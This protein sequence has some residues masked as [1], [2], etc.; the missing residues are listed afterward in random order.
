MIREGNAGGGRGPD[1]TLSLIEIPVRS[2]W[3]AC[4]H[5]LFVSADPKPT[6]ST[7]PVVVLE[8]ILDY[9][10]NAAD[11]RDT[12]DDDSRHQW[13]N[14]DYTFFTAILRVSRD[15]RDIGSRI[16]E[17]N[18]F[19][20][21]S[22]KDPSFLRNLTGPAVSEGCLLRHRIY[23]RF[24]AIA[25]FKRYHMRVHISLRNDGLTTKLESVFFILPMDNLATF[26]SSL[27]IPVL[28]TASS[29]KLLIELK[30]HSSG[31]SLITK[32]Q[33]SVLKPF[34]KLLSVRAALYYSRCC[35]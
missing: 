10:L 20:L 11:V 12:S 14:P 26:I 5:V 8:R 23:Y 13:L 28:G 7:L 1:G 31:H 6:F 34:A 27:R 16:F 15:M 3:D 18:H 17:R 9:L 35:R 2:F 19:V 30:N 29:Y 32:V 4:L 24:A 25:P 21:F 22:T 33:E